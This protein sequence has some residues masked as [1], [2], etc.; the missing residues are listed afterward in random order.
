[1]GSL[2]LKTEVLN[3]SSHGIWLLTNDKEIFLPYEEFPWFKDQTVKSITNVQ[4][5]SSGH[6]YWP[7]IDVDLTI[8][9]IEHLRNSP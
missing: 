5:E 4:E 3:I 2:L 8:E 6:F 1:M 7:N 9:S